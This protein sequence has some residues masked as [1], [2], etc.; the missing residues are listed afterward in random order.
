MWTL[1]RSLTFCFCSTVTAVFA[2]GIPAIGQSVVSTHSGVIYYFDGAVSVDNQP[3]E[4]HM[5]QFPSVPLGAELR[6]AQGHAEVLL[7]PGV[8]LRIGDNSAI[9][10]LSNDLTNAR[11]ELQAGSAIVDSS[12]PSS[13]TSVTLIFKDWQVHS[14]EAGTYRI[15]SDPPRVWVLKGDAEVMTANG[16]RPIKVQEGRD[17]PLATALRSEPSTA[18]P[19]DS[20]SE[21]SKG[22]RESILA[23]NSITQ[24]ID[25]DPASQTADLNGLSGFSYFPLVGVPVMGLRM[26]S[27]PYSSI[28]PVQPGFYSMYL[29][30]YT[31]A[32]AVVLLPAMGRMGGLYRSPVY[33]P[34]FEVSPASRPG[35]RPAPAYTVTP[36]HPAGTAPRPPAVATRSL[37]H[38][39]AGSH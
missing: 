22:R 36:V 23:D 7:T 15:D 9:R 26:Y 3:L 38:H 13:G 16:G 39:A 32:P 20:L 35:V 11:V 14:S 34:P 2:L 24:Q 30:G 37:P 17:L 10:M 27:S 33:R 31:Y 4:P 19:A 6:T 28:V 25:A 18:E 5:G 21:W 12:D 29:P 1:R 8:L